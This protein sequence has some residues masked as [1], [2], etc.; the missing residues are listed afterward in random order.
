[1]NERWKEIREEITESSSVWNVYKLDCDRLARFLARLEDRVSKKEVRVLEGE[2][3]K[4]EGEE[5][6][7]KKPEGEE[8][9]KKPEG[10]EEKK[11]E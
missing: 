8:E 11:E 5:E 2:E 9:E 10:E 1:M 6:E 7:E 3:K 4:P